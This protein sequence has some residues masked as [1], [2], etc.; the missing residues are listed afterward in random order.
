VDSLTV[1]AQRESSLPPE[2]SSSIDVARYVT[3]SAIWAPSVHN[4]QPWWFVIHRNEIELHADRRRQLCVA[5]P[6]GREMLISCGAAL[7]TAKLAL[8]NLGLIAESRVLPDPADRFL[9]ARL[10]WP[11][12]A[13]PAAYEQR[14]AQQVTRRRTHR[15][16]FGPVPLPAGLL[17][18]LRHGA[19][20]DGAALRV[21]NDDASR[22]TLAALVDMGERAQGL[23]SAYL[24]ELARWAPAPSDV[25]PDGVSPSSYPAH[26]ERTTPH[27]PSRD[28]ARGHGWGIPTPGPAGPATF[29]GVACVLTTPTDH[30]ADWVNAGHALQ[31][32]LLT[33][34]SY[35]CA[36]AL[37]SQPTEVDWL[38]D[39][40]RTQIGD[41]WYPQL[42]LRLGTT[43]QSA[44][45]LRRPLSSVMYYENRP[46]C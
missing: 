44:V 42:V 14:L 12:Q 36:V 19:A 10:R 43:V 1:P 8:R 30:P 32:I 28:F 29:A 34:A 38:R 37:H 17:G 20:K 33:A 15:G 31:R 39:A 26:P 9:I 3:G 7:F 27:F 4:T 25:R 11:R 2:I 23:D 24:Q 41:G 35:G 22:A 5:D 13:A 45:S 40:I 18:V 46:R 16:G 21:A 6:A